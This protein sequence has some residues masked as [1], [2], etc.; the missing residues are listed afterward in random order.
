[1]SR[2]RRSSGGSP[3]TGTREAFWLTGP[4]PSLTSEPVPDGCQDGQDEDRKRG[5]DLAVG[6]NAPFGPV[7]P[8][9]GPTGARAAGSFRTAGPAHLLKG[10]T[11]AGSA[12]GSGPRAIYRDQGS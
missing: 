3:R 6:G 4:L 5:A 11:I 1:V 9:S 8:P 10:R 12:P 7:A 2:C